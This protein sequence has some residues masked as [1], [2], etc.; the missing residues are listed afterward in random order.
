M[1]NNTLTAD[2]VALNAYLAARN[3]EFEAKCIAEGATFWC[4]S[5]ITAEDLA[6]YGVY[7]VEQYKAWREEQDALIDAKEARKAGY[8]W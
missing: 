5:A 2:Q 7:T 3:A 1:M 4:V 8:D 6:K